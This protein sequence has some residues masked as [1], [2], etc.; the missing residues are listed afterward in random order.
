MDGKDQSDGIGKPGGP[1]WL[2]LHVVIASALIWLF[3]VKDEDVSLFLDSGI[4]NLA[5]R[6]AGEGE[7]MRRWVLVGIAMLMVLIVSLSSL[8]GYMVVA[9]CWRLT[10]AGKSLR[11]V[12]LR[13]AVLAGVAL[14][15]LAILYS[16]TASPLREFLGFPR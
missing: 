10:T 4:A 1:S 6:I 2:S 12:L 15:F 7:A 3:V 16:N 5:Y 9:V 14:W 11:A 8:C 13:T